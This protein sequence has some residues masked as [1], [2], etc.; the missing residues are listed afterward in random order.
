[1]GKRAKNFKEDTLKLIQ[2]LPTELSLALLLGTLPVYLFSKS[3]KTLNEMVSGLLAIGP[4]IDYYAWMLAPYAL[5][6]IMKYLVRFGSDRGK[7]TF[8]F[9]HRIVAD[10]GTGFQTI[11]RTGAGVAFGVLLL[12]EAITKHT[13][14]QYSMLYWMAV[15]PLIFSCAISM[16]RNEVMQRTEH[17]AYK[18]PLKLNVKHTKD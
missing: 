14:E 8:N 17:K 7:L 18:N 5:L 3:S 4:L 13:T 12:P 11:L 16:F 2:Q 9:I 15:M 1:M 6:I 10:A